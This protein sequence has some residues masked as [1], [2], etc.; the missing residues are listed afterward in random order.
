MRPKNDV[1][2]FGH[3]NV[4]PKIKLVL[5]PAQLQRLKHP[6]A[7]PV[8][9]QQGKAPIAGKRQKMRVPFAIIAF[10]LFA[11]RF[12]YHGNRLLLVISDAGASRSDRTWACPRISSLPQRVRPVEP[13]VARDRQSR[14]RGHGTLPA[15]G[16][17]VDYFHSTVIPPIPPVRTATRW[18]PAR[19]SSRPERTAPRGTNGPSDGPRRS[20]SPWPP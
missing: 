15:E 10:A 5:L 14:L 2:V 16:S 11:M 3:D 12:Q 4:S 13:M 19:G 20:P 1:D 6:I 9:G 18:P 7:R 17:T 8:L